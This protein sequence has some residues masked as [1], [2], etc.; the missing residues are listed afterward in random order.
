MLSRLTHISSGVTRSTSMQHLILIS[1]RDGSDIWHAVC[2]L[3]SHFRGDSDGVHSNTSRSRRR[4]C[5][6][7]RTRCS[8]WIWLLIPLVPSSHFPAEIVSVETD[9]NPAGKAS[10]LPASDVFSSDFRR[11]CRAVLPLGWWT[12]RGPRSIKTSSTRSK[13]RMTSLQMSTFRSPREPKPVDISRDLQDW[14]K[15]S[16]N[17]FE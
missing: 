8:S 15:T 14:R 2:T 10:G 6:C 4:K 17:R 5:S 11:S 13:D 7:G 12:F 1:R 3:D 16:S 9:G